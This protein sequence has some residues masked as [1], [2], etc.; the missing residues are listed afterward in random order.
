M[1]NDNNNSLVIITSVINPIDKPLTYSNTRSV[2]SKEERFFQTLKTIETL[3]NKTKNCD[4][5]VLECSD[6]PEYMV[7]EIEK[8]V[9]IFVNFKDDEDVRFYVE[10]PHK[11]AGEVKKMIKFIENDKK[12]LFKK[13]ENIF[14]ISGRYWLSDEFVFENFFLQS[15]PTNVFQIRDGNHFCTILYK[16]NKSYYETF[17]EVLKKSLELKMNTCLGLEYIFFNLFNSNNIDYYDLTSHG[18]PLG[19]EGFVFC[20][21]FLRV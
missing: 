16:I 13:Y 15:P 8:L 1:N 9:D 18:F 21:N 19:A 20:G 6:L 4:I 2:Y 17:F 14:K 5:C 3:K 10:S 7:K 11:G 12:K